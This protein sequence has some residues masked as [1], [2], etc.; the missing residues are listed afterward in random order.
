MKLFTFGDSYTEGVGCDLNQEYKIISSNGFADVTLFR[1]QYSWPKYLADKLSI[2]HT[3]YGVGASSNKDIFENISQILKTNTISNGDLV[4]V[5][6]SSSLRDSVPYFPEEE[7]HIWSNRYK[8]KKHIFNTFLNKKHSNN[9]I[10]NDSLNEYKLFFM[11]NLFSNVYYDYVNQNYILFLQHMFNKMNI[12]YVFCDAF[13]SMISKLVDLNI[14]NTH[15]INETNYWGYRTKTFKD[16]LIDFNTGDV[17]ED[18]V[19]WEDV[20]GKHPNKFGYKL[21]ADELYEF[22]KQNNILTYRLNSKLR[23]I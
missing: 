8:E 1:N 12:R 20:P 17:W 18:F 10:Y 2:E 9:P 22:I 19:K 16:F 11:D 3:N 21:I 13:D 7:W 15:L 23:L 14:D 5:M 4:I 6:W